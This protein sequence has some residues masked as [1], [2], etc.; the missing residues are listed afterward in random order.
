MKLLS[1][2]DLA[3]S[4]QLFFVALAL[5]LN[6]TGIYADT[7][8][9]NEVTKILEPLINKRKIPGYYLAVFKGGVK[10]LEK[11]EGYADDKTKL[12]TWKIN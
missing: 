5:T 11:S 12:T 10:V 8:F 9:E 6:A 3:K 1:G 7:N 4:I 2:L